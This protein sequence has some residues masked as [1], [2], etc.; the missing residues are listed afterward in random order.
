ML[1]HHGM[2]DDSLRIVYKAV[3]LSKLLHAAPAW[4]GFTSAA[5]KQRLEVSIRRAVRSGLY[6]ADDT[7]FL[8]WS[9]TWTTTY[10]QAFDT[11]RIT[12]CTNFYLIKSI[13]NTIFDHVF[14]LFR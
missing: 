8:N 13:G 7:Y 14:T 2:G 12:F 4:W 6:A 1:R 10:L 3:V 9:K 5:D 11:I